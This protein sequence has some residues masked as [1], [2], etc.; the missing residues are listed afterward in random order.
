MAPQTKAADDNDASMHD[1]SDD[2]RNANDPMVSYNILP[3]P[4][5]SLTATPIAASLL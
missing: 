3:A 5:P 2:G 1:V 4:T